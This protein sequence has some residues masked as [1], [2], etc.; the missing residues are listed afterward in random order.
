[1]FED[2]LA[3]LRHEVEQADGLSDER[4][5]ALREHVNAIAHLGATAPTAE[6]AEHEGLAPLRTAV[7]ELE[8]SHPRLTEAVNRIATALSNMGI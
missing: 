5:A 6:P 8:A 1:M 7:E 4:K 2:L 3:Q